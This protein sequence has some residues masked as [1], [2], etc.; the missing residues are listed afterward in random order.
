MLK[1]D[2]KSLDFFLA[3][4]GKYFSSFR[5]QSTLEAEKFRQAWE[6]LELSGR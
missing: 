3:S 2:G 1:A 4:T 5:A 6:K